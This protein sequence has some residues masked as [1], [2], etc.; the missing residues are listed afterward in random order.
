MPAR[1]LRYLLTAPLLFATVRPAAGEWKQLGPLT[2]FERGESIVTLTCGESVVRLEATAEH[3]VRVRVAPDGTFGRDFS[4]AVLDLQPKGRFIAFQERDEQVRFTTGGV[5]V[6]VYRDP[7]RLEFLDADNRIIAADDNEGG[8]AWNAPARESETLDAMKPRQGQV[9]NPGH[10]TAASRAGRKSEIRISHQLPDGVAIYGLGEKSGVLNKRGQAWEMWNLDAYGYGP[11]SDPIYVSVPFFIAAKDGAYSGLFFD[12]PW[13]TWFDFGKQSRNGL[14]FGAEGGEINY[15]VIAG[16]DPKD[17]VR[18]YTDLVGRIELPPYWTLGYHQCRYSYYPEAKVREIATALRDRKIPCDVIYFDIDYMDGYRCFTWNPKWFPDPKALVT[19]LNAMDFHTIAIIDPG[20]KYDPG[21]FVFDQ[22]TKLNAWLT[23]PDGQPYV[24]RVWPGKTVFPDFTNPKVRNW[25]ADLYPPFLESCG[26]DGV[27]NDMNEPADFD[28]PNKTVPLDI[29]FDNEG[30]PADHRACHNVYGMQMCRATLEGLKRAKPGRRAF[31]M[32]RASY[33]GGQRYGAGWTGDNSSTWEHLRMSIPMVLNLG[34][35]GMP[36][37]GPDIG[38]FAIGAHPELYARWI[39]FGALFPYCRT[40]TAWDN[41]D[42]EPW[43]YGAEVEGVARASIER[44]YQLLPYLYTL[45]EEASRTGVPML[46]P[47]WMEFPHGGPSADTSFMLGPDI[48]VAPILEPNPRETRVELPPGVWYDMNTGLIWGGGQRVP[49][50]V[51]AYSLPMFVR[52][53]ATIPMQS[54][55]QSTRETPEEPLILDVWPFGERTATLYE[56]DG[57]TLEFQNGNFRRTELRTRTNEHLVELSITTEG[58][59]QPR[60][61]SPLARVHGID[62]AVERVTCVSGRLD[63]DQAALEQAIAAAESSPAGDAPS[64]GELRI[65]TRTVAEPGMK[66]P[67]DYR[68]GQ[69]TR[70]LEVRLHP[71]NGQ[72][73]ILRVKSKPR[74]GAEAPIVFTFDNPGSS[75]AAVSDILPPTYENGVVKL[76]LKNDWNPNVLLP[77]LRLSADKLPLLKMRMS[78]EHA[79]KLAVRFATEEDPT[80]SD[81]TEMLFDMTP[82]GRLHDY[83]FDLSKASGGKWTGT[84]YQVRIDFE[85]GIRGDEFVTFDSLS[86]EPRE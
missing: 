56:D 29:R 63:G 41:P 74:P 35:S 14:S 44:R 49:V 42:Q 23:R 48:Y 69:R 10:D 77:R 38:G 13:R 6:V 84:V 18:R 80:L 73:Q 16:P 37:Q 76:S 30:E 12:N 70:I 78:S 8:A 17:V 79:R 51:D 55:V 24:G 67:G 60:D 19:D 45:F 85:D 36:F 86:F 54:I 33:A 22:G 40:H 15:Y 3:V 62:G 71:D 66:A 20:I 65:V 58:P 2:S 11:S 46:R 7:S 64:A 61:R 68:R 1:R 83:T 39:Q 28:G 81:R 43:S 53:G 59:Y 9:G 31:T 4:W 72:P 26:I 47:V 5:T 21:Y 34:V 32:T 25:W 52:G 57:Q 50:S 82:D 27:W 75:F